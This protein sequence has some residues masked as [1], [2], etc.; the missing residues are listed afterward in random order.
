MTEASR[1]WFPNPLLKGDCFWDHDCIL[2][3]EKPI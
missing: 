3:T 2:P 1:G